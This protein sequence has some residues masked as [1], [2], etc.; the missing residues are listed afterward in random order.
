[1]THRT[2]IDFEHDNSYDIKNGFT[3]VKYGNNR[4]IL[5]TELNEMQ[6]I[7]E[8]T[9][10][11]L[12]RQIVPSGFVYLKRSEINGNNIIF[13]PNNEENTIALAPSKLF[14]NGYELTIEGNETYLD[15]LGVNREGYLKIKLPEP[16]TSLSS[17]HFVF[18]ECW[19]EELSGE[20]AIRKHG[21]AEGEVISNAILDHRV[22]TETSRRVGLRWR[23]R[24]VEDHDFDRWE[25]G[26]G[27][28]NDANFS[29]IYAFGALNSKV[30]NYDYVFRHATEEIFKDC[31][32]YGDNGLWVAG[33][34]WTAGDSE[35]SINHQL[36]I[37]EDYVFA[38]PLFKIKRRNSN[39]YSL[40][41]PNGASVWFNEN[42][43]STHPDNLFCNRISSEDV[44]DLRRT[45]SFSGW[46]YEQLLNQGLK[47]LVTG[48]MTTYKKEVMHR[49]QFGVE[50]VKAEDDH[51][52]FIT[53]FNGNTKTDDN[54]DPNMVLGTTNLKYGLGSSGQGLVL[55]GNSA[56]EYLLPAFNKIR[57]GVDF[58]LRPFWGSNDIESQQTIFSIIDSFSNT[59]IFEFKK[60]GKFITFIIRRNSSGLSG[61]EYRTNVDILD[62]N[63][64]A[65]KLYHFRIMWEYGTSTTTLTGGDRNGSLMIYLNG[66]LVESNNFVGTDLNP[67]VLRIGETEDYMTDSI[68]PVSILD[69]F[70]IYDDLVSGFKQITEDIAKNTATLYPSFNGTLSSFNDNSYIQK[71]VVKSVVTKNDET[72]L[73]LTS[74]K[75]AL[76][77]NSTI[78]RVFNELGEEYL[79]TW[80]NLG[81]IEAIFSLTKSPSNNN[82][83]TGETVY[84]Q[85]DLNVEAGNGSFELPTKI[86]KAEINNTEVSFNEVNASPRLISVKDE[87]TGKKFKAYDFNTVRA[88]KDCH[89]RIV[90]YK[91][92]GNGQDRYY[93]PH[94]MFGYDVIGIKYVSR[95]YD[96]I[97]KI[98]NDPLRLF[99][100]ELTYALLEDQ[101]VEVHI[102]LGGIVFDYQTYTKSII[103]NTLKTTT[104]KIIAPG[105]TETFKLKLDSDL[106]FNT[107][108]AAGNLTRNVYNE[109]GVITGTTDNYFVYKNGAQTNLLSVSGFGTPFLTIEFSSTP[110]A[111]EVIEIPVLATYS[112]KATDL[113]SI[114]FKHVPYQG[115]MTNKPQTLNKLSNWIPFVTTLSSG[116][117]VLDNL[118]SKSIANAFNRLPGGGS[119]THTLTGDDI[120]FKGEIYTNYQNNVPN[121]K[122]VLVKDA[123]T[124][125][126][127][128]DLDSYFFELDSNFVVKKMQNRF[129]DGGL[130]EPFN[131]NGFFMKDTED[132]I[133]KYGGAACLVQDESGRLLL[134]VIGHTH[135]Y[136]KTNSTVVKPVFGDLFYIDSN[137]TSH[138]RK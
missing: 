10:S 95:K 73:K 126:K 6:K 56:I 1:M 109:S 54:V 122:F 7:Q 105:N 20:S 98:S 5:E 39:E 75:E 71:D 64:F 79:G 67:S 24:I 80:S 114:W 87:T 69:E 93:I 117:L 62:N 47:D 138:R 136:E 84:V 77:S 11:S 42:S 107:F 100:I 8:E 137:P 63:V 131:I 59:K 128:N 130:E 60:E 115:T 110:L 50:Q 58:F 90:H 116:N 46:N 43:Q 101:E 132:A 106:G 120:N 125:A 9:R 41:N 129:Q 86:L 14:L 29:P 3:R 25:Q 102:M 78:P 40:G 30:D 99:E 12:V 21:Y 108:V 51:V 83:F 72:T 18:L 104:L 48:K 123:K 37:T 134:F 124:I 76:I 127:S 45:I 113:V 31:D 89:A 91:I 96:N 15:D 97:K 53:R 70:V 38:M 57:G 33:R 81:S 22:N 23:I 19:F 118:P 44:E 135:D 88:T 49:A 27:Y 68:Y 28:L 121:K 26:F 35:S 32:F 52:V 17:D 2:H 94:K 65:N 55:D 4:K 92:T 133:N 119:F 82:I 13:N 34:P 36:G 74:F 111:G 85:Y 66:K 61:D 103:S 16:P 112:L